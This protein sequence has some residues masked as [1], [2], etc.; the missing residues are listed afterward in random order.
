MPISKQFHI[1]HA[2]SGGL[3]SLHAAYVTILKNQSY[4]H[5]LVY[6]D[7]YDEVDKTEYI[8]ARTLYNSLVKIFPKTSINFEKIKPARPNR[9]EMPPNGRQPLLQQGIVVETMARHIAIR[10]PHSHRFVGCTVGWNQYDANEKSGEAFDWSIKDYE[11]LREMYASLIYFQDLG[12][13]PDLMLPSWDKTKIEMWNTLPEELR[14]L[15]YVGAPG[16][17]SQSATM[18]EDHVLLEIV[19]N[20]SKLEEYYSQGLAPSKKFLIKFLAGRGSDGTV[21]QHILQEIHGMVSTYSSCHDNI[22]SIDRLRLDWR[23][24]ECIPYSPDN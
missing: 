23:N 8:L 11:R 3:D 21:L 7:L 19:A 15:C 4:D 12:R 10:I 1:F 22:D 2:F 5:H 9:Y 16:Q 24:I 14:K 17:S 6:I 18:K 13:Q 20:G